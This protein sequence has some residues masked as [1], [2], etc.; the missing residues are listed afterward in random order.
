MISLSN[1]FRSALRWT[2][3]KEETETAL[4][5]AYHLYEFWL[6]H[7]DF[8]E[9]HRLLEQ[10][11][12]LPRTDQFP[13][14]LA[15]ALNALS[16][17]D[18]F[19]GRTDRSI[20]LSEKAL[21]LAQSQPDNISEVIAHLNLGAIFV[22]QKDGLAIGKAHI[23]EASEI[24]HEI[25]TQ[26]EHARSLM[27]LAFIYLRTKDYD[28]SHSYYTNAYNLYQEL[29]DIN[30]QS[31]T[32]R[33]IGDLEI[34]RGS[35]DK[36]KAAYLESLTIAQVVKNHLQVAY[37]FI[38]LSNAA[39][40]EGNHLRALKFH[41]AGKAILENVGIWS[42]GY[43]PEWGKKIAKAKTVLSNTEVQSILASGHQM[44]NE[45]AFEFGKGIQDN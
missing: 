24:S 44:T 1:N 21:S 30:F 12:A 18:W 39:A 26:W 28:R 32:K 33:L 6:R 29:G 4:R 2:I 27:L 9:G 31:V 42:I 20:E 10:V 17:I 40:I 14:P 35:L 25:G 22:H 16:W 3:E 34:E 41:M 36:G 8:E 15:N 19:Q 45:E 7:A 5:F 38:G 23:T 43:E 13:I 37:N 11:L